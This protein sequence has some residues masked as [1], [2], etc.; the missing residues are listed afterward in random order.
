[1]ANNIN[2]QE[3]RAQ[4][5]GRSAKANEEAVEKFIETGEV[6][7]EEVSDPRQQSFFKEQKN[8]EEA[9]VIE[10]TA[11]ENEPE[12]PVAKQSPAERF[13]QAQTQKDFYADDISGLAD[14]TEKELYEL[15]L[16]QRKNVVRRKDIK[17]SKTYSISLPCALMDLMDKMAANR[18]M[19][20][21]ALVYLLIMKGAGIELD[22]HVK[23]S[24]PRPIE[25]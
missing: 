20:R 3:L 22:A 6:M 1:M 10:T 24:L 17:T 16:E 12:K 9:S 13:I 8:A 7:D 23:K 4:R 5:A 18:F 2:L 11:Q 21:S 19:H 14:M 25:A 15:I